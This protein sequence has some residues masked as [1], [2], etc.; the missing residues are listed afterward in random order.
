MIF[1]DP[2]DLFYYPYAYYMLHLLALLLYKKSF[3][4]N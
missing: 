4:R 1:C 3:K 2:L